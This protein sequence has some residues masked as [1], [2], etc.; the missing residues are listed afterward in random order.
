M[1]F[2]EKNCD[3]IFLSRFKI[4]YLYLFINKK[5]EMYFKRIKKKK[6]EK[7]LYVQS[8]SSYHCEQ[9]VKC[10]TTTGDDY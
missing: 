7:N 1:D 3:S 5:K 4:Q 2:N 10:H 9:W 6:E 8:E